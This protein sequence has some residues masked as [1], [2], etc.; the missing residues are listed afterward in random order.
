MMAKV[1][2]NK[3]VDARRRRA[4]RGHHIKAMTAELAAG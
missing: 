1:T 2:G 3:T 4:W